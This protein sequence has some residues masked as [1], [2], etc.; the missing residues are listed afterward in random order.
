MSPEQ[1]RFEAPD[2]RDRHLFALGIVLFEMLSGERLYGAAMSARAGSSRSRRRTS[3]SSAP[4]CRTSSCDLLFELLA[5]ERDARP[6]DAREVARRL[7]SIYA[8]LVTEEDPADVAEYAMFVAG[9]AR[10]EQE[11]V[12]A[13][14]IEEAERATAGE[15]G[16]PKRT[17]LWV[18]V[19]AVL[20][21]GGGGLAL[22]LAVTD[23]GDAAE[24]ASTSAAP[25]VL[26]ATD[27]VD[28]GAPEPDSAVIA[29]GETPSHEAASPR[30]AHRHRP[31]MRS[32]P[33][34]MEA[35]APEMEGERLPDWVD[36]EP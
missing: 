12:L 24:T 5:K 18:A 20:A 30:R 15:V 22:A 8:R 23:E 14:A 35:A 27:P 28:A 10:K 4:T 6:P 3:A 29:T 17:R 13:A 32:R 26:R 7:E 34:G 36:F 25:P 11:R 1:L 33:R 16:P 19:A 21:V 9:D 31:S 2:R